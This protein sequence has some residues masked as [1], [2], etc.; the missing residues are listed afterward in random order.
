MKKDFFEYNEKNSN[1]EDFDAYQYA[2]D[3]EKLSLEIIIY[4]EELNT[5]II[6]DKDITQKTRDKYP[7]GWCK[8][9]YSKDYYSANK[10]S[11]KQNFC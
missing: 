2:P 1:H 7:C 10:S 5:D 6:I 3:F 8:N 9:G 11:P 4:K